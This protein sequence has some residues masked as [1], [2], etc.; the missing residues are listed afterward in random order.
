VEEDFEFWI[1]DRWGEQIYYTQTFK[2]W[3]GNYKGVPAKQDV[4]V[5][6][7]IVKDIFDVKHTYIGKVTLLR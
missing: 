7:F 6:K 3:D 2:P 1:F 4:Y 5:Y